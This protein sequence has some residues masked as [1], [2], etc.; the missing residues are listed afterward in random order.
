MDRAPK[1]SAME[2]EPGNLTMGTLIRVAHALGSRVEIKLVE[3]LK[4]SR[5]RVFRNIPYDKKCERLSEGCGIWVVNH[6]YH[7]T[8]C[9]L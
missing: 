9:F 3:E 2:N 5:D 4:E 1:I 6:N 8:P 7:P